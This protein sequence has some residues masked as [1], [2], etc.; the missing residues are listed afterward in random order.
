M[1]IT[2]VLP[3]GIGIPKGKRSQNN[4][5]TY[6]T[7]LLCSLKGK[8][9]TKAKSTIPSSF[10]RLSVSDWQVWERGQAVSPLESVQNQLLHSFAIAPEGIN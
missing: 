7:D 1:A 4:G 2:K 5:I 6:L 10:C 9:N 3:L 8:D